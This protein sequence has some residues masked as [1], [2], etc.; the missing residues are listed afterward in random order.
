ME[1]VDIITLEGRGVREEGDECVS[2]REPGLL[3][4]PRKSL[5]RTHARERVNG[6]KKG[7]GEK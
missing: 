7:R 1:I 6:G 4:F 2:T 5:A 3:R